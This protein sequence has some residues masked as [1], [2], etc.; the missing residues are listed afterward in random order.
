MYLTVGLAQAD[1]LNIGDH[2]HHI[3]EGLLT[4]LTRG[5]GVAAHLGVGRSY[6][7]LKGQCHENW[8]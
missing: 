5:E 2:V 1:V 4:Y 7:A 3:L 8:S 6:R